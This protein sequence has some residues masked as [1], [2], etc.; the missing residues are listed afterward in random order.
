[1][2]SCCLLVCDTSEMTS[3][4]RYNAVELAKGVDEI[5][6]RKGRKVRISILRGL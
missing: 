1:M 3:L 5:F 6:K 2:Y 4:I